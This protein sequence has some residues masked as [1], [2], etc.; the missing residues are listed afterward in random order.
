MRLFYPGANFCKLRQIEPL[1][2]SC[3]TFS[4]KSIE[5]IEPLTKA[6]EQFEQILNR[7]TPEEVK[8]EWANIEVNDLSVKMEIYWYDRD[9]FS[10]RKE[11]YLVGAHPFVFQRFGVLAKDVNILHTLS[12]E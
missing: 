9:F 2:V 7:R 3:A 11:A 12:S 6:I 10:D 4:L 1:A 8:Y 5:D